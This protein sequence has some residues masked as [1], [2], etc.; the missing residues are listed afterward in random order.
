MGV[1]PACVSVCSVCVE[2]RRFQHLLNS[3]DGWVGTS[4]I[5]ITWKV[6]GL[7]SMSVW[8]AQRAHSGVFAFFA[9]CH[10]SLP[11]AGYCPISQGETP[12][13]LSSWAFPV[14]FMAAFQMAE[15]AKSLTSG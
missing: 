11:S 5:L 6:A 7:V 8:G 14:W 4:R 9:T 15:V 13:Q 12:G 1:L 3:Q 2:S 10:L